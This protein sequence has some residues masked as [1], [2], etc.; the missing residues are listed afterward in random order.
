MHVK[1]FYLGC[2]AHAS[3]LIADQKSGVAAVIDPQR[4]I[5]QYLEEAQRLGVK[6][7][8]VLLTHFHADFVAGDRELQKRCGA[9]IYFGAKA[10]PEYAHQKLAD[11]DA[12][13]FGDTRIVALTTPG[14]T[15]EGASFV[16]YDLAKSRTE[17][18]AVFTGDTLFIGDVGRPDLLGSIGFAAADLA[19]MLYDSLHEKLLKLPD[20][21]LVYPTHGAGSL[22]G[23]NLSTETVST[24]GAQRKDN[25]AVQPMSRADFVA[26]ITAGQPTAPRYFVH[27]AI[28]NRRARA[29]VDDL[30]GEANHALP[31]D[32][33]LRMQAAGAQ[34]VDV[35]DDVAVGGGTMVGAFHV[36]LQGSFATWAG[37]LL[38]LDKDLVVLADPGTEQEAIVRLLRVGLDRVRGY[39]QGGFA[40]IAS[41]RELVQTTPQITLDELRQRLATTKP[42]L[43]LDVRTPTEWSAG[44][45]DGALHIPLIELES[46]MAEVPRDRQLAV[47]CRT[48]NRSAS[49][50]GL[51]R[52]AGVTNLL[53][54]LGG[55]SKWSPAG[56]G[57]CGT[58][59]TSC[60]GGKP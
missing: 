54:V 1:Q 16:L 12:I 39:L 57:S 29:T 58:S 18:H 50:V 22:C 52:R 4:D 36:P 51:L 19:N 43:V 49:A 34:V 11:G 37:A 40:A 2:L 17:P 60:S 15:P 7:Q 44:H 8:H 10:R 21:T 45:I 13:E 6:I 42:P 24:I 32:E 5:D 41:R 31:L 48:S 9:T 46:R 27:D 38:A 33:V 47:I 35:R 59:G 56:A 20:A 23:K 3:Y 25:Y 55:M 28:M 30:I 14:H 53:H 26:M